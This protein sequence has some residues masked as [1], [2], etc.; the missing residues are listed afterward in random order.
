[1]RYLESEQL[2]TSQLPGGR[3]IVAQMSIIIVQQSTEELQHSLLRT[4]Q[5][6]SS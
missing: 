6:R 4:I 5:T 1:M 2:A 3:I